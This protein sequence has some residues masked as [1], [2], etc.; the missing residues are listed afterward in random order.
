MV[1]RGIS[2]LPE[3]L[4]GF[5]GNTHVLRLGPT[6]RNISEK[7]ADQMAEQALVSPTSNPELRFLYFTVIVEVAG[8][9]RKLWLT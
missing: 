7:L 8:V 5:V 2:G 3:H 1:S 9:L 6:A 4:T